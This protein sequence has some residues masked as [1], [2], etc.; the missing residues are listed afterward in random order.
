MTTSQF[1][2]YI[3]VEMLY[4]QYKIKYFDV[5]IDSNAGICTTKQCVFLHNWM[6]NYLNF[7]GEISP[8]ESLILCKGIK[9][10]EILIGGGQTPWYKVKTPSIY[11][12]DT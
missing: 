10:T 12:H 4:E 6:K 2:I 7:L 5:Y 3:I 11:F 8:N 9:M 1:S